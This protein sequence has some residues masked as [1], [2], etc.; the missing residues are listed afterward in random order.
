MKI[1][2]R[3]IYGIALQA[4]CL[5]AFIE[6]SRTSV[7]EAGKPLVVFFS[8]LSVLL[9]IWSWLKNENKKSVL[10]LIPAV[11]AIGYIIAFHLVGLIAFPSLLA[12]AGLSI[13]YLISLFSVTL[14][15]FGCCLIAAGGLYL[16]KIG[17][18]R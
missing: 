14:V 6:I 4:V 13:G 15:V 12:D 1:I 16:F 10:L 17:I 8:M 7:A 3:G 9:F 11:L 18:S 5:I 2:I